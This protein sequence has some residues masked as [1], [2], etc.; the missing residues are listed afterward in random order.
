MEKL[1]VQAFSV[2]LRQ[3]S[4]LMRCSIWVR[5]GTRSLHRWGCSLGGIACTD[6]CW[7]AIPWRAVP[8]YK[9][10]RSYVITCSCGWISIRR[11]DKTWRRR[12]LSI[13]MESY[14][15][16]RWKDSVSAEEFAK[17]MDQKLV[18]LGLW[19]TQNRRYLVMEGAPIQAAFGNS[20]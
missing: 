7:M 18:W 20:Y 6:E 13:E 11:R 9:L 17:S 3:K 1:V 12:R 15:N 19:Y 14:Q 8:L 2:C 4:A 10:S 5:N 16:R